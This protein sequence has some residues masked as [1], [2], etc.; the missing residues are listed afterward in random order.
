MLKQRIITAVFAV[1]ALLLVLFVLPSAAAQIVVALVILAGAWEWSGFLGA[2]STSVR[3]AYVAFIAVLMGLVTWQTP[4]INGLL[5]RVAVAWWAA[6]LVWTF[7]FP[8]PIPTVVRW[9]AG[10]LVLLPLYS[11]LIVLY[12]A[13]PSI[14]LGGLLIV[15]AADT[16]AFVAGKLFGR[17]KLAPQISPGKS[18]EG[19]IGGL[20]TVA[21]VALVGAYLFDARAAVLVPF[22]LAVACVSI[23]GDLTV[24]MFKRTAA[25]KD[26]GSLFPGHGG[27]LDRIDSVAA[28][29]PLIALGIGWAGLQ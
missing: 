8:T 13:S 19:V 15:W 26:S 29:A 4:Q 1:A 24:S 18:W 14:L 25:L 16:G 10:A 17:V 27:V 22:C 3:V 11:A 7:F 9:V 12:V 21:L 28:A 23:I 5:F 6:A 20:L 2:R